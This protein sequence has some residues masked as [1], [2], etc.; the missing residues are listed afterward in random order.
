M[1]IEFKEFLDAW[2][3]IKTS[4]IGYININD[5]EFIKTTRIVTSMGHGYTNNDENIFLITFKGESLW[6]PNEFCQLYDDA[7][8]EL[9]NFLKCNNNL[10]KIKNKKE[11]IKLIEEKSAKNI[12]K[13]IEKWKS[14]DPT[15]NNL[16]GIACAVGINLENL[17]NQLKLNKR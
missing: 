14:K 7:V 12:I 11:Q 15:R 8:Q 1:K 6:V 9:S 13:Q 3:F 2:E 4:S 5:V 16:R 10:D 17:H